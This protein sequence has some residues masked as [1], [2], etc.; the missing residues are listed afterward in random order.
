MNAAVALLQCCAL[1]VT[2]ATW[3]SSASTEKKTGHNLQPLSAGEIELRGGLEALSIGRDMSRENDYSFTPIITARW[4]INDHIQLALPLL[5][6]ASLYQGQGQ[7]PTLAL[8]AGISQVE[9]SYRGLGVVPTIGFSSHWVGSKSSLLLAI[10]ASSSPFSIEVPILYPLMEL[11]VGWSHQISSRLAV[12]FGASV[13][14]VPFFLRMEE[15]P[16]FEINQPSI[17]LSTGTLGTGA[18]TFAPILRYRFWRSLVAETWLAYTI[19]ARSGFSRG[20]AGVAL[21]WTPDWLLPQE[22]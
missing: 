19:E 2:P 10:E 17:I 12:G 6:T 15:D 5:A 18:G 1:A 4:G 21:V 16:V 9:L 3:D 8:S 14:T 22:E 13:G 20:E 7:I 11:K